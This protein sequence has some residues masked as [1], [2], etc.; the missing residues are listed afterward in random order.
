MIGLTVNVFGTELT[1]LFDSLDKA[2]E[3]MEVW[4]NAGTYTILY[5]PGNK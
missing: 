4:N 1:L 2:I 5:V 3:N